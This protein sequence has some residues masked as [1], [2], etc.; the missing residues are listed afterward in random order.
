MAL[1][2][3]VMETLHIDGVALEV[4][5]LGAAT[6]LPR[7]S[8]IVF[9]HEGLGSVS[10]WRQWPAQVCAATGRDGIVYSRQGYGGSAPRPDVRGPSRTV[11]G[12]RIGRL[13]ADYLHREAWD[14]LP[15]LLARLDVHEP[16]LIGHSDG[17]SIALIH[18]ARHGVRAC[19]AMAPHVI[20]EEMSVTAIAAARDAFVTGGLRE[21]LARHHADVDGAFWQWNDVWLSDPFRAFDI[22]AL[23]TEIQAPV[24][25]IQGLDDPYGSMA[26]IDEIRPNGSIERLRLADCAHSPHRDRPDAVLRAITDFLA[27]LD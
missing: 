11:A 13:D 1:L 16:V 17:G 27:P 7:R 9:L 21:G 19:V 5:R 25:A 23:C 26:Q 14:V 6:G 3:W 2:A 4:Q 22:R 18:A 20:V 24:L 15:A 12:R 10:M 8:P